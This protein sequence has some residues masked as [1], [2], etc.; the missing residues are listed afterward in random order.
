MIAQCLQR[1]ERSA[2]E[3]NLIY[4]ARGATQDVLV[5]K[6]TTNA[7][8]TSASSWEREGGGEPPSQT[9]IMFISREKVVIVPQR[10]GA[11]LNR[12]HKVVTLLWK[13][14]N[15]RAGPGAAMFEIYCKLH[16]PQ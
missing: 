14:N 4:G 1:Q 6:F 3:G 16:Q 13:Y 10:M 7:I 15:P 8:T 2:G 5:M 12:G 11:I 9:E